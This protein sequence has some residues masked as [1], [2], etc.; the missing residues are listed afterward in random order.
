MDWYRWY[1]ALFEADT[2]HL[3]PAQDG[4]YRRLIDWYMSKRRPL[5]DNDQALAAI[6]RIGLQEW[7]EVAPVIR[8]FFKPKG[9]VLYQKRCDKE[10]NEQDEASRKHSEIS[11]KGAEARWSN[12]KGLDAAGMPPASRADARGEEK[13]GKE[14][15][16]GSNEP[17]AI[18]PSNDPVKALWDVGVSLLTAANQP[19]KNA[20]TLIGRWRS[21]LG[22]DKR[23]L[24]ILEAAKRVGTGDPVACVSK[25]VRNETRPRSGLC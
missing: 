8:A 19:E 24:E 12:N 22:D 15:G 13:R 4:I 21:H 5:P 17:G 6:A 10:L 14:Q 2:M 7:R 16:S 1:P 3:T 23:L 9:G 11:K 25:A 18:A 20:R